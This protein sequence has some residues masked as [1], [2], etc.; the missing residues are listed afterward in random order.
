MRG[1]MSL[2]VVVPSHNVTSDPTSEGLNR[3][4]TS[5]VKELEKNA[6]ST[7]P[8]SEFCRFCH[9][10]LFGSEN[11]EIPEC[12]PGPLNDLYQFYDLYQ[13]EQRSSCFLDKFQRMHRS[14]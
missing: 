9:I 14:G 3:Q 13:Y 7:V 12:V 1:V 10:Y 11:G 2:S 6:E 8:Q 5:S 4:V